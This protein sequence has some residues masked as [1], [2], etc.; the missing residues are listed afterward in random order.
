MDKPCPGPPA[1][2]AQLPTR[3]SERAK[4]SV[5]RLS[6]CLFAGHSEEFFFSFPTSESIFS[7][8]FFRAI[9]EPLDRI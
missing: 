3:V 8:L 4:Q 2:R 5:R 6:L 7:V 9:G 1:L